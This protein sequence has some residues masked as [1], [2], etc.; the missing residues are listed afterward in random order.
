MN[1]LLPETRQEWQ[2]ALDC[3]EGAIALDAARQYGLVRGG[4][5]VNLDRCYQILTLGKQ[6]GFEPRPDAI[7]RFTAALLQEQRTP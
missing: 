3:A 6:R 5:K 4:P 7:E 2:D 1:A